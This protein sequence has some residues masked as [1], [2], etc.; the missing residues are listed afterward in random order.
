MPCL[1]HGTEHR[2]GTIQHFLGVL[3]AWWW[4]HSQQDNV[5]A[6]MKWAG[7]VSQP[8]LTLKMIYQRTAELRE[9]NM[10]FIEDQKLEFRENS[11]FENSTV[12]F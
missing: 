1:R 4:V 8:I 9:Q 5:R 11:L 3:L 10:N 12:G 6:I 7:T 2:A